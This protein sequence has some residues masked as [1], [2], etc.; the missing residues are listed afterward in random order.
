MQEVEMSDGAG[1]RKQFLQSSLSAW[2]VSSSSPSWGYC[3]SPWR[4][5]CGHPMPGRW[6]ERA[7]GNGSRLQAGLPSV[8]GGS[9]A[10]GSLADLVEK[11][12]PRRP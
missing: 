4:Q 7:G 3:G 10:P 11:L 8:L 6:C 12:S 1:E 2:W 9:G 5:A